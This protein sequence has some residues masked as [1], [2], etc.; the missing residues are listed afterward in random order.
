MKNET[1]RRTAQPE[2]V[3]GLG[4]RSRATA[5]RH[6]I[7]WDLV[8]AL[9]DY[10]AMAYD[11]ATVVD[12]YTDAQALICRMGDDSI[13]VAFRGSKEPQDFIQDGK[14]W[15]KDLNWSRFDSV[16]AVH[17]GFLQDF[18]AVEKEVV[19]EVKELL[20]QNPA[21]KIYITGHSLGG[22][23]VI[24]CALEF[25]R[26]KLPIAGV[27][28]FGQPRVGNKTFSQIYNDALGNITFHIVNA[29]DPVPLLPPLLFDYRDEGNEIFLPKKA[30][31]QLNP[32]IGFE[33]IHNCLGM[34]QSWCRRRLA[35][36]PNHF[37]SAYQKRME[38]C[39]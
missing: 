9:G 34:F 22:A 36:L 23:I 1:P 2:M 12:R 14:F 32:S 17:E 4:S 13:V 21:A 30:G 29:D 35:F 8:R 39:A 10:A 5:I 26:L 31:W 20:V 24:L 27:Y 25:S 3:K 16:A 19:A 38:V 28:T 11:R 18:M 7:D 15:M 33:F 6:V 37:M